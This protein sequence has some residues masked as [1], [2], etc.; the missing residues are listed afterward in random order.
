MSDL[1]MP[2]MDG[3]EL[4]GHI[5]ANSSTVDIP[6]IMITSRAAAKHREEA[7]ASGVN[8]YLTKPYA[9]DEL[10]EEIHRLVPHVGGGSTSS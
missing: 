7:L 8:I 10:L 2:R 3:L 1:E 4:T 5:R 9:E 6:I